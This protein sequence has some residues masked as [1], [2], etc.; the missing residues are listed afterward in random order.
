M[1]L[2]ESTNNY[3]Y[4][5][6]DGVLKESILEHGLLLSKTRSMQ[7]GNK[8]FL[9]HYPEYCFGNTCFRI[10]VFGL[11]ISRIRDSFEYVC[12]EDIAADRIEYYGYEENE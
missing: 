3:M 8:I 10:N 7:Y 11:N 1:P 2:I 9:S 5:C 12:D 6:T 4:H